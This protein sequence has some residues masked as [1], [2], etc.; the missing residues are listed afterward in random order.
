M[1]HAFLILAH[2]EFQVL[3][4]LVGSLDDERNDIFVH[5]DKKVKDIPDLRVDKAGLF[6]LRKRI[7]VTW[8]AFSMVKAE[9]LLF[10]EAVAKGPYLFYHLLSGVDLP[11]KSQDYIHDFF[12]RN[13]GKEFISFEPRSEEKV[14]HRMRYVHIFQKGFR[15][16]TCILY[17]IRAIFVQTQK[18]LLLKR[19]RK[20]DFHKGSQWVS[21]TDGL[22]R[23]F[24]ASRLWIRRVFNHTFIPDESVFQTLCMSSSFRDN[25]FDLYDEMSG[26][27][28]LV[29]WNDD[30]SYVKYWAASDLE[31]LKSSPA[32]F[33]RK[34]NGS[35]PAFLREVMRLSYSFI[36]SDV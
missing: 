5:F 9:E 2:N 10:E 22:A 4:A 14:D 24:V 30:H 8:G 26:N 27:Q 17:R 29:K 33:A 28:R 12:Q 3:Q 21:V 7:S 13:S 20:V 1:K 36:D 15:D 16:W 18:R 11:L 6:V 19:N 32:L 23:E 25:I 34:F 31:M 35:D